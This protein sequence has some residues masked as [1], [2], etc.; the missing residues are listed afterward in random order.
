MTK[1]EEEILAEMKQ[2][3][4]YNIRL[5]EKKWVKIMEAEKTE[6]NIKTFYDLMMETTSRDNF[7]WNTFDYYKIFLEELDFSKLLFADYEGKIISAWI[8]TYFWKEAIYYYW[9]STSD[10]NFRNLMAPYLLQWEAIKIWK[11]LWCEIY[12]FLWIASPDDEN[13]PLLWVTDFKLKFTKDS[14]NVSTSFI[15]K[16][17]K[18]KYFLIEFLRKFKK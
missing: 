2:K 18:F 14:K 6:K 3:W 4:R 5:A 9:A 11:W 17:K 13:S 15:Y 8:F 7:F 1:S 16:H 10:K 12:D